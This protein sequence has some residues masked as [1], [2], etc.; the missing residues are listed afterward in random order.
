MPEKSGGG[1]RRCGS[2]RNCACG[3]GRAWTQRQPRRRAGIHPNTVAKLDGGVRWN[4]P[5]NRCFGKH[6]RC[7]WNAPVFRG[8]TAAEVE[9]QPAE[10]NRRSASRRR[11]RKT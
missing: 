2:G 1:P 11:R 4:R 10:E 9:E 5:A 8:T 6:K 3:R 7:V